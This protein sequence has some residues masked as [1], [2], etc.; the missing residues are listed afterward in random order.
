MNMKKKEIT[1]RL[2][3][4]QKMKQKYE[5][6]IKELTNDIVILV[7]NNNYY[8]VSDVKCRWDMKIQSERAI[9]FGRRQ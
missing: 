5:A 8:K 4:Y 7:E 1:G 3:S 6:K 9:M 2:S